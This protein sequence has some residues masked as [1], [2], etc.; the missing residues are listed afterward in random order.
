MSPTTI[1]FLSCPIR[2]SS[3][4]LGTGKSDNAILFR[5]VNRASCADASLFYIVRFV[6]IRLF[7]APN[8]ADCRAKTEPFSETRLRLGYA[9]ESGTSALFSR[10]ISAKVTPS[11]CA[12]N[13]FIFFF[14]VGFCIY[15]VRVRVER[16]VLDLRFFEVFR[17]RPRAREISLCS[18]FF[19]CFRSFIAVLLQFLP[20]T[21]I[22]QTNRQRAERLKLSFHPDRRTFPNLTV[23]YCFRVRYTISKNNE[24][25]NIARLNN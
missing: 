7:P 12:W 25:G 18:V 23:S 4:F 17:F 2:V 13:E 11:A 15:S 5:R 22:T 10:K 21:A 19:L 24:A 9:S 8:R 16:V 14:S 3:P 20:Q 1:V 6:L